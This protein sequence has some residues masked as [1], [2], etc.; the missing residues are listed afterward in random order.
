M[1]VVG[2]AVAKMARGAIRKAMEKRGVDATLIPFVSKMVYYLLVAFVL[3]AVLSLFGVEVTSI[4][5]VMGAAAFA[6]G[7]ALQ[8]TLSN[9]A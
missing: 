5:A 1:L 2:M 3:V 8:G 6:V 4:I 7:L 9:F